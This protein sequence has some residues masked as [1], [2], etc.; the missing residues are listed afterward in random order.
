[1]KASSTYML[2]QF[3]FLDS[4]IKKYLQHCHV[5][6]VDTLLKILVDVVDNVYK[7]DVWSDWDPV[8]QIHIFPCLKQ[9]A[10][11]NNAS[12][13]IGQLA[14]ALCKVSPE[15]S[16][17]GMAYFT[18]DPVDPGVSARFALTLV[19]N[20]L[21]PNQEGCII[22]AWLRCCL[23]STEN[24]EELT[25]SVLKLHN[26]I[27]SFKNKLETSSNPLF[28]MFELLAQENNIVLKETVL[29]LLVDNLTNVDVWVKPYIKEPKSEALTIHIY[30]NIAVLVY[31]FAP[32]LYNK[33]KSACLLSRIIS[34]FLLPVELLRGQ[35]PHNYVLHSVQRTWHLYFKGIYALNW[36]DDLFLERTL[37]DLIVCYVPH[38]PTDNSPLLKCFNDE[39]MATVILQKIAIAF[40]SHSSK[41]TKQ[42]SLKVLRFFDNF[43]N[44]CKSVGIMR[45]IA[46]SVLVILLEFLLFNL[47]CNAAVSTLISL[48]SSD[49]Y[50]A[51]KSDVHQSII[52]V[53]EKHLTFNSNN[54][55]Q[56]ALIL[57]KI[58]PDDIKVLLPKIHQIVVSVEKVRGDGFDSTLRKGLSSIEA[59]VSV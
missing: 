6:D 53:T 57:V 11:T 1:M 20:Q 27:A 41:C 13:R 3:V 31:N 59:A 9:L 55:F 12:P 44:N 47:H 33:T 36:N 16:N 26:S 42:H 15:L 45:F 7:S 52:T 51:V 48:T 38:F 50:D 40:L 35:T 23:L 46:Q 56:L 37:K 54:Y 25:K 28:D 49:F 17:Q 32:I 19:Q 18:D 14:A 43:M 29:K 30:T 21:I 39:N 24:N 22:K 4:W 2:G 10:T 5:T 8:F 34:T 58:I